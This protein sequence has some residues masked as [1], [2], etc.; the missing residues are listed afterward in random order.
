MKRIYLA[1]SDKQHEQIAKI[2]K[3][4]EITR[5]ALIRRYIDLGLKRIEQENVEAIEKDYIESLRQKT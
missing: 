3:E 2:A 5:T 4:L 1:V